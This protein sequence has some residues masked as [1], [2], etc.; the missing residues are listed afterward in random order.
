[1]S[2]ETAP[3]TVVPLRKS[4]KFQLRLATCAAALSECA[5]RSVTNVQLYMSNLAKAF[6]SLC[7]SEMSNNY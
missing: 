7:A 3:P 1:M 5:C 6:F 4:V 2:S